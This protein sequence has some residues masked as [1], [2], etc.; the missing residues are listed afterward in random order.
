MLFRIDT[1]EFKISRVER[2]TLSDFKWNERDLQKLL[3]RNL[4]EVF[5]TEELL[6]ISQ[7]RHFQE[8]NPFSQALENHC[9]CL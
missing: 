6:I 9:R 8:E 5:Q 3:F 2:T 1:D 7:S 4:D